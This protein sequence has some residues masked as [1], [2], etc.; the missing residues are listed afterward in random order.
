MKYFHH[1]LFRFD[2][3]GNIEAT[4]AAGARIKRH[5]RIG[6]LRAVKITATKKENAKIPPKITAKNIPVSCAQLI[7][8]MANPVK[9]PALPAT[10]PS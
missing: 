9:M 8:S 1:I 2:V 7:C 6:I 3:G 10:P 4:Q 5:Q